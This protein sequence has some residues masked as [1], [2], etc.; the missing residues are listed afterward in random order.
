[1]SGH[2]ATRCARAPRTACL[3]LSESSRRRSDST[4]NLVQQ[5]NQ[6]RTQL[7][8]R[9]SRGAGIGPD[10]E[11]GTRG[12]HGDPTCDDGPE[13]PLDAV[14]HDRTPDSFG[15]DE[16]DSR[17][18]CRPRVGWSKVHH[19]EPV[20]G[21]NAAGSADRRPEV[22]TCPQPVRCRQHRTVLRRTARRD[23]CGVG[24]RGWRDRRG[25]AYAG[26]TRGSWPGDGCW[27]G[28]YACSRLISLHQRGTGRTSGARWARLPSKARVRRLTTNSATSIDDSDVGS[29]A[30]ERNRR[31]DCPTVR[32][33]MN[34]GQTGPSGHHAVQKQSRM[35]CSLPSKRMTRRT[36][37]G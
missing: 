34:T 24:R 9:R 6:C 13:P 36:A 30:G 15:D 32:E 23:P 25:C 8:E 5:R 27:A 7:V 12:D 1:M 18:T 19:D 2:A 31:P 3:M 28:T 10:H 16:T 21:T 17:R 4:N 14:T 20:A 11:V 26:G 29:R 35:H 33:W 37:V 22:V